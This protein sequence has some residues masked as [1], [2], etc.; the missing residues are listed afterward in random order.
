MTP[1]THMFCTV[2]TCEALVMHQT[3][4]KASSE[5]TSSVIHSS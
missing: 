5:K 3:L 2:L 4:P 1:Q